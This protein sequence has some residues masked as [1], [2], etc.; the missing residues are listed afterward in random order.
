MNVLYVVMFQST[1]LEYRGIIDFLNR[2]RI[3][4]AISADPVVSRPYLDQFWDTAEQDY[5]VTPN[6]VR[7]TVA[8]RDI[9]ISEDTIRRVLQFRDFATD[10]ISYPDY[11]MDGCWR[12][13]MGYV[14]VRDYSSYKKMWVLDQW[15]YFAYIIIVCISSRKTGKYAMGHDLAAATVG[16]SLN[17]GY[18]FSRY[19]YKAL[20]NQ[21]NTTERFRFLLYTRFVQ[22]LINDALPNL[23]AVGERLQVKRVAK[24]VFS[25]F[26]TPGSVEPTP[27]H[28]PLFG[29]L[30]NEVYMAPENWRWYSAESEPEHSDEQQ[31]E[32]EVEYEDEVS[33]EGGDEEQGSGGAE[34]SDSEATESDSSDS[35]DAPSQSHP[36]RLMKLTLP[37]SSSKRKTQVSTSEYEPDSDSDAAADGKV[38]TSVGGIGN[39]NLLFVRCKRQRRGP[40][41]TPDVATTAITE[42][43]PVIVT[44]RIQ[45]VQVVVTT[46]I[47]T[48][49]ITITPTTIQITTIPT[50]IPTTTLQHISE[51][52]HDFGFNQGFNFGEFFFFPTNQAEASS[53]RGPDPLDTRITTLETQVVGLLETLRK[54][55]EESNKQQGHINFLIDEVATL[56][57][58]RAADDKQRLE[59]DT[60]VKLVC[61]MSK[62]IAAQG[63]KLKELLEKQST[64]PSSEKA[65]HLVDLTKGDDQDKDPEAETSGSDKQPSALAIVPISFIP[66]VEGEST[67]SEGGGY[68]LGGN[69]GKSVADVLKDLSD[70]VSDDVILLLEP[71]YSKEAQIDALCNLEEGEIE[72]GDDWDEEDVV[73]EVP[74]G[75]G[76]GEYEFED[77]EIFEAPSFETYLDTGSV[78]PDSTVKASTEASP[79]NSTPMDPEAQKDK[80]MPARFP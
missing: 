37:E 8:G 32:E 49:S 72:S 12:Q 21:I 35:D 18:N 1:A 16:L 2:L 11:F 39:T 75:D 40:R 52:F 50:S 62:T 74:K 20:I 41:V 63:E 13:R 66:M 30:I 57:K 29:H 17:R 31:E 4:Y 33:E 3:S 71:D 22:L 46:P 80:H 77:G 48:E 44:L 55:R 61:D 78:E 42:A 38:S 68:A 54:S 60:M 24:R 58:Q 25:R 76:E 79:A 45:S 56:K 10:P 23:P 7:A 26:L 6:V 67:Q 43:V 53:S 51:P 14:G 73:I 69:K 9:A 70:D 59:H 64:K 47:L 36:R 19:V 34:E 15:T 65:C 27:V 5:T 28:T